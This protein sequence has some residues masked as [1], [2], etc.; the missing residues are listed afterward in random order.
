MRY[1]SFRLQVWRSDRFGYAQWCARLEGLQDGQDQRFT[2]SD[3][4]LSHL[5]ALLGPEQHAD[6]QRAE[7]IE[8]ETS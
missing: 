7:H 5:R 6:L 3:A 4:L 1:Q 2:S 8:D